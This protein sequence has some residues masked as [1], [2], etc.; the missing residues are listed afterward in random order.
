MVRIQG[1]YQCDR[2]F[3][4]S[5]KRGFPFITK[6]SGYIPNL[7]GHN[8]RILRIGDFCITICTSQ[9]MFD[10]M[11]KQGVATITVRI[12]GHMCY[13]YGPVVNSFLGYSSLTCP[14]KI[15]PITTT[16]FPAIVEI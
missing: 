12:F 15:L 4:P 5:C 13:E 2:F 8:G 16:P 1:T 3:Q 7:P 9:Y 11:V 6:C 14:L 10:M